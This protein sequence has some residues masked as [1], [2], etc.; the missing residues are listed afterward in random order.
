MQLKSM[1]YL[2]PKKVAIRMGMYH[3]HFPHKL[4]SISNNFLFHFCPIV[5]VRRTF[6]SSHYAVSLSHFIKETPFYLIKYINRPPF[7]LS[8]RTFL[9]WPLNAFIGHPRFYQSNKYSLFLF[10]PH[11][12]LSLYLPFFY[13]PKSR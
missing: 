7:I 13:L 3:Q 2:S 6:T 9:N 8:Q 10:S 11:F 1:N 4:I 5:I 12:F